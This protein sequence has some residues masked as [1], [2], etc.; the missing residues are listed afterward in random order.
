MDDGS[1]GGALILDGHLIKGLEKLVE[2]CVAQLMEIELEW[3][4]A[5]EQNGDF[6]NAETVLLV[7]EDLDEGFPDEVFLE[8]VA[9]GSGCLYH[10]LLLVMEDGSDL[11][12]VVE[13][14][15]VVQELKGL[16][17]VGLGQLCLVLNED[18]AV[19]GFLNDEA[20]NTER[21][22]SKLERT[23]MLQTL[24]APVLASRDGF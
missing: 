11:D 23:E 10:G 2:L 14:V 3:E 16:V 9:G 19:Y 20:E 6:I 12:G 5:G 24:R 8:E 7:L 1:E 17:V 18:A 22:Q 4:F 13:Q 15:Q 21:A